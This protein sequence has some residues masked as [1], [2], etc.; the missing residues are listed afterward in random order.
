MEDKENI[1]VLKV[2]TGASG[3]KQV[4][5]EFPSNSKTKRA[6]PENRKVERVTQGTVAVRKKGAGKKLAESFLGEDGGSI[7]SYIIEDI[8]MPALKNAAT[9]V[10]K[11]GTDILKDGFNVLI[12]GDKR[13]GRPNSSSRNESRVSY[14]NYSKGGRDNR[15]TRDSRQPRREISQQSRSRHDFDDI[16][17]KES[18]YKTARAE[19]EDVL[20]HLVELIHKYDQATVGDFYDLAGV[21]SNF[22]DDKYGW[23]E[24]GRARTIPVRGGYIIDFPKPILLD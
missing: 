16:V 11:Y 10:I 13:G 5:M 1:H 23:K 18:E 14:N 9:D 20:I 24:L 4:S 19:A 12:F 21:T 15:D 2:D 6:V 8:V 7:T 3:I 22:T 17:F